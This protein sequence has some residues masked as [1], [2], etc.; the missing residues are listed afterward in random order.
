[1]L[2]IMLA[3]GGTT[4]SLSPAYAQ[5]GIQTEIVLDGRSF[6]LSSREAR[7]LSTLRESIPGGRHAIQDA[8]LEAARSA[9]DTP[10]ARYLFAVYALDIGR[11]RSDTMLRAE[12]L[13]ILIARGIAPQVKLASYLGVRGGIA[14]E[15]GDFA[16]ARQLWTRML[17][18]KPGD[19]DV[20]ANL[21]QVEQAQNNPKGAAELI[22]RAIVARKASGQRASELW[23]RQWLS[24]ANQASLVSE[25]SAAGLALVAAYPSARNWH[26]ALVV[27]R[28]LAAPK[29]GLEIDW[30]RFSRRVG[31]FT[32][33]A[34]YQRL[35]QL[36]EHEGVNAE[37]KAVLAEGLS[38][39]ILRP[40]ESPT[41]DIIAEVERAMTV[42]AGGLPAPAR[43]GSGGG[44]AAQSQAADR[45][46]G[47]GRYSDAATLYRAALNG[48]AA[49]SGRLN[50][51][52]GMA[53]SAAGLGLEAQA[54]FRSAAAAAG[55]GYAD[56]ARFWLAWLA[57]G[58]APASAAS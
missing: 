17:G 19:A 42:Q 21:A 49:E 52:L 4:S 53:L 44:S 39:A 35:A 26:D 1:M 43:P 7:A 28:Q 13:D 20:L 32:K 25:A 55:S 2:Q 15:R 14:F 45:L 30:L 10:D 33:A 58:D 24:A 31:G 22:A 48:P 18:M 57:Q 16:T 56:L 23:Y 34:E 40:D 36:L 41:R 3:L 54:A 29:D 12:A 27:Y 8:A 47:M 6:A 37:A 11:Q 9:T 38:G 46:F 50:T 5:V 51:R